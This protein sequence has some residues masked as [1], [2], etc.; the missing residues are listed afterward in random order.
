MPKAA[1]RAAN[2]RLVLITGPE[3][4]L[5]RRALEERLRETE[6]FDV[7]HASGDVGTPMDWVGA[8]ATSPF[9]SARRTVV[10]RHLLRAP[11][12]TGLDGFW[13]AVAELPESGLLVL[14]ADEEQGDDSRQRTLSEL[15]RKWRKAVESA[16]GEVVACDVPDKDLRRAV[17]EEAKRLGKSITP[18][19][20]QLLVE[21][22]GGSMSKAFEELAKLALYVGERADIREADVTTAVLPDRDWDVFKLINAML[23]GDVAGAVRQL[24]ILMSGGSKP[25]DEARQRLLPA[26]SKQLR[27]M[28]Q[29][30]V[31]LDDGP[32][33]ERQLLVKTNLRKEQD[34][35]QRKVMEASRRVGLDRIGACLH[36]LADTDAALKGMGDSFSERD[37]LELM[38]L[39]MAGAISGRTRESSL[40]RSR[41]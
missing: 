10:V 19:A 17:G 24:R 35:R 11:D 23:G 6:D 15:G 3:D 36:I 39:S 34:W 20:C 7:E 32:E 41:H 31:L 16:G 40:A 26:L 30:R 18:A 8:A 14:V 22:V 1:A 13:A 25:G 21:M 4:V 29:A 2:P 33:G 37:T 38:I 27:L 5:R 12:P 28:W 9:L